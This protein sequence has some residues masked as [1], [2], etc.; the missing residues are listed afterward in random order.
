MHFWLAPLLSFFSKP[1]Y[2]MIAGDRSKK[3]VWYLL[4]LSLIMTIVMTVVLFF[5]IFPKMHLMLEWAKQEMPNL[6]ITQESIAMDRPSPYVMI[7]PKLGPMVTFNTEHDEAA[8]EE[9]QKTP[10]LVTR[11][12]IYVNELGKRQIYLLKEFF[13]ANPKTKQSKDPILLNAES[14]DKFYG[15]A[16][17]LVTVSL[18]VGTFVGF[19]A[20]KLIVVLIYSLLGM[21]FNQMRRGP[22]SYGKVFDLTIY[23][24]T[25]TIVFQLMRL[26]IPVLGNVP[27]L[28]VLDISISL[29]YLYF[30]IK[31]SELP[32]QAMNVSHS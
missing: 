2:I 9:L 12:R 22:L 17:P 1:F 26:L 29:A 13:D 5:S 25:P 14:L 27:F 10:I 6:T 30:A 32:G 4:F 20:W 19:F 24:M 28:F 11:N 23:S 18:L 31:M 15:M 21:T 16:K 8:P 3:G 7:H